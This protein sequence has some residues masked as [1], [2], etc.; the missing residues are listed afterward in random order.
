M[1]VLMRF[2]FLLSLSTY[3]NPLPQFLH[4][5]T[6]SARSDPVYPPYTAI[7]PTGR[8]GLEAVATNKVKAAQDLLQFAGSSLLDRGA[9]NPR[10]RAKEAA[11]LGLSDSDFVMNIGEYTEQSNSRDVSSGKG[12]NQEQ[13]RLRKRTRVK[14]TKSVL[15]QQI[16]VRT[17]PE[18]SSSPPP[19][20][21]SRFTILRGGTAR[22][23]VIVSNREHIL[24]KEGGTKKK[25]TLLEDTFRR[26]IAQTYY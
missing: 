17:R 1:L 19:P 9:L 18:I 26:N 6:T 24:A 2:L 12:S 11:L 13:R 5:P 7:K 22:D 25:I 15:D 14:M 21:K 23:G 3:T 4:F 20:P 8:P 16:R 10:K